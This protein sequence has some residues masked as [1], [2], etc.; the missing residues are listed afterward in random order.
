MQLFL[1]IC[2]LDLSSFFPEKW[3]TKWSSNGRENENV[4]TSAPS[5]RLIYQ[6]VESPVVK[7]KGRRVK[8]VDLTGL[9]PLVKAR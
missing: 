9:V 1:D 6:E 3:R 5:I 4:K 2:D 8:K 7:L